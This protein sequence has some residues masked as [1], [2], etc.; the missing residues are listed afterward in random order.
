MT[1]KEV[2]EI[3]VLCFAAIGAYEVVTFVVAEWKKAKAVA[4]KVKKDL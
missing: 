2:A 1:I 4:V 3:V